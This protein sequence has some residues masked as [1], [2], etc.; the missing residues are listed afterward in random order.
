MTS[1]RNHDE[2]V[3]W[4]P[5]N[6]ALHA[7]FKDPKFTTAPNTLC[8]T[9][10]YGGV[11]IACS[12]TKTQ[13]S[14][15]HFDKQQKL[16]T[17]ATKEPISCMKTMNNGT[18]IIAGTKTGSLNIWNAQSGRLLAEVKA[19]YEA[20]NCLSLASDDSLVLTACA[21]GSAKLWVVADLL[22]ASQSKLDHRDDK[23]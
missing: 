19:H 11:I 10:E 7:A 20:I 21:G 13:V 23:L 17:M 12:S 4:D 1:A 15:W 16:F 22:S 8:T 14:C 18:H 2:I 3:I 5:K 6:R 9:N